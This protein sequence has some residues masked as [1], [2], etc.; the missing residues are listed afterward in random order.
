[1]ALVQIK[2]S[3]RYAHA[4]TAGQDA[5]GRHDV[6][7]R[8]FYAHLY[9]ENRC[10]LSCDHC[11]ETEDTHPGDDTLTL[12]QYGDLF[13]ELAELGVMVL[14]LSGGEPFLRKDFLDIV[15]LARHKRFAVRIY[16]SGTPI[17]AD[18]ADRMQ[19]L[20]VSEVHIS[21]YS[22][23]AAVHD[24]FT[25]MAGSHTRSV[26]AM[27]MLVERGIRVVMKT[28]LM[29]INVDAIDDL[30]SLAE[31]MGVD[32]ELSPGLRPKMNGDRAPL[33][34]ALTAEQIAQTVHRHPKLGEQMDRERAESLCNGENPRAGGG[35]LCGA[36]SKL[37]SVW[38]DGS[39]APCALFPVAGG[40]F[41]EERVVDIFQRST[42][43]TSVRAA[44]WA[45]QTS[46]GSCEVSS[47]CTPCMASALS[48]QDD[49]R[50]CSAASHR[51]ATA[52]HLAAT[53]TLND[54]TAEVA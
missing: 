13:D 1:M 17:T 34:Y 51:L 23:V 14:T 52:R 22:H 25:G 33:E 36:G 3:R 28:T 12:D 27:Q 7:L 19:E 41:G 29:T 32:Y 16:T 46:C 49:H 20:G 10:H 30:V 21:I 53:A 26:R 4:K 31:G 5:V 8:P 11:Y 9:V 15:A 24:K 2:G 39:I 6:R 18:K 50:A 42:L 47:G 54:D 45:D 40:R 38:A 35:G 44:R 48:E 43:F 37:L